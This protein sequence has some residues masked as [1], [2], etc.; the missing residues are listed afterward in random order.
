MRTLPGRC[1]ELLA[2]RAGQLA[3]VIGQPYRLIFKPA[4]LPTP[5]LASGGLDWDRVTFINIL[6]VV[7]YHG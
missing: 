4:T 3:L 5:K 7:D 1:H 2:D 6:E